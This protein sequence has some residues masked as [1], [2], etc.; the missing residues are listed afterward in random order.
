MIHAGYL[1]EV[2]ATCSAE[3]SKRMIY[4]RSSPALRVRSA[5]PLSANNRSI[6]VTLYRS[7]SSSKEMLPVRTAAA[8]AD[9]VQRFG[10]FPVELHADHSFDLI[11]IPYRSTFCV[12]IFLTTGE[13]CQ[14]KNEK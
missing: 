7:H 13:Q 6:P 3:P 12:G 14:T 4:H 11:G 10:R 2:F 5:Q 8:G 9:Y 1:P